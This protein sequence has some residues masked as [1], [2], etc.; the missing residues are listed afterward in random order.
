MVIRHEAGGRRRLV[1]LFGAGLI[2]T[3]VA[4]A[5]RRG[6]ASAWVTLPYDW[7]ADQEAQAEQWAEIRGRLAAWT[8]PEGSTEWH[9]IWAAGRA[10]FAGTAEQ[11]LGEEVNFRR[12][13][14]RVT[15]DRVAP[16]RPYLHLV[17]SAGG[18]FEG[19]MNVTPASRPAPLRPYGELKAR[20]EAAVEAV[21]EGG[22]VPGAEIYRPSSVYGRVD[23]RFRMGL[24]PVLV[25]NGLSYRES[26]IFGAVQTLRD[27]VLV[28]DIGHFLA[29]RVEDGGAAGLR[30][31]FLVGGASH[32][33]F[34]I[35]HRV[36]QVI[37]RPPY[38]KY[39]AQA[40][41]ARGNS[42]ARRCLPAGFAATDVETGIRL[43]YSAIVHDHHNTV[44][45][46]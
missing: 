31:H 45:K 20:Q 28:D 46:K 39:V 42:Y 13:L 36:K 5:L 26:L 16:G 6:G 41:F 44:L 34:E 40:Q 29:R 11:T 9:W 43:V 32:A 14:E 24:I 8:G 10:G 19:Q 23:R 2:G 27:Y 25:V 38:V 30:R 21:V 1:T 35:L 37:G 3:A 4:R 33:I 17:S 22:L 12:L 7:T 18:L 15:E